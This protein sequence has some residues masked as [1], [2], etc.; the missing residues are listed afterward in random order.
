MKNSPSKSAKIQKAYEDAGKL[1]KLK[2]RSTEITKE[3]IYF[4]ELIKSEPKLPKNVPKK[5]V[6]K[7]KSANKGHSRQ[8]KLAEKLK[9][10]QCN[11]LKD[12]SSFSNYLTSRFTIP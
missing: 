3:K 9:C 5:K 11:D 8:R 7:V 4:K 2:E 1:F 10:S 6:K 12:N